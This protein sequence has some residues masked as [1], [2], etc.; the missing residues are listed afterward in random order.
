NLEHGFREDTELAA[1]RKP[2][3]CSDSGGDYPLEHMASG[4]PEAERLFTTLI[5][6]GV[7]VTSTL[8]GAAASVPVDTTSDTRPLLRPPVLEAMAPSVREAYLYGRNRPRPAPGDAA[9]RLRRDMDLQR[10]FVA[11]GG[12]LLA[13]SDPVGIGGNLPG[14]GD[15]RQIELLVE[16]GFPPVE[17]IRIATLNGATYLGRE[18]RIGSIGAGKNADLGVV[19]G[20]PASRNSGIQNIGIA[21]TER[22][23]HA[24]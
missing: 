14:F 8:S 3:T 6:H 10:A 24:P 18:D 7:A 9:R 17:A 2:D 4:S 23:C 16:A 22:A 11:K 5:A 21:F 12:L 19:K 13:G 20:G 1:G 15:Q